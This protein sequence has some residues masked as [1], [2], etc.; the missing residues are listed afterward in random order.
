MKT[1]KNL[2]MILGGENWMVWIKKRYF[3]SVNTR[4][5]VFATATGERFPDGKPILKSLRKVT[6]TPIRRHRAIK[7]EA[8]PFDP[9][10]EMYFEERISLK[11]QDSLKGR[12]KLIGLWLD[13]D[14]RCPICRELITRKSG[15]HVH[16]IVWRVN[17]GGDESANLIMVHPNC[18]N[19]I[20]VKGIKVVKPAPA[21]GL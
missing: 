9:Q 3:H 14:R 4:K 5:W 11:M 10:W 1:C 12:R 16:H 8:N 13:Q 18:H 19:Q 17:G 6:D 21:R 2:F 7:L 15:W 20:H